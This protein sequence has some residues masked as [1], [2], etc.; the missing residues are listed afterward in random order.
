MF[1]RC[2][3]AIIVSMLVS[4]VTFA[5]EMSSH[6]MSD[7]NGPCKAIAQACS[8]AGF[9]RGKTPDKRFWKDCM[10]PILTGQSVK[11][12]NVDPSA[13]KEC[14]SKKIDK[15]KKEIKHLENAS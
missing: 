4:Q 15:M 7:K 13:V 14:R 1:N 5:D 11:G 2:F 10:Q 8:A 3:A 12:V 9:E 6:K